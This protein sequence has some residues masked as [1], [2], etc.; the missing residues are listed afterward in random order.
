MP[1]LSF[2]GWGWSKKAINQPELQ[3]RKVGKRV[4]GDLP[5]ALETL[6]DLVTVENDLIQP[7][8]AKIKES[9]KNAAEGINQILDTKHTFT[10]ESLC[11]QLK[12]I[13]NFLGRNWTT[14]EGR[15][16]EEKQNI[17]VYLKAMEDITS[18]L[19]VIDAF[20]PAQ[21]NKGLFK[22]FEKHWDRQNI[23]ATWSGKISIKSNN[24]TTKHNLTGLSAWGKY[25]SDYSAFH[26]RNKEITGNSERE[27]SVNPMKWKAWNPFK[28]KKMTDTKLRAFSES[29]ITYIAAND[30]KKQATA[31]LEHAQIANHQEVYT[32]AQETSKKGIKACLEMKTVDTPL[33]SRLLIE[34]A[35]AKN[36]GDMNVILD[37][38]K[39][40]D[41]DIATLLSNTDLTPT[42]LEGLLPK[43]NVPDFK[44]EINKCLDKRFFVMDKVK[45]IREHNPKITPNFQPFAVT[46][47]ITPTYT[48]PKSIT[49]INV[50][51]VTIDNVRAPRNSFA[52]YLNILT[53]QTG[54]TGGT[55]A[56]GTKEMVDSDET[57]PRPPRK[58]I[59]QELQDS[60]NDKHPKLVIKYA[61]NSRLATISDEKNEPVTLN[62]KELTALSRA[63]PF[64]LISING[65]SYFVDPNKDKLIPYTT[66]NLINCFP[67]NI[68]GNIKV[69]GNDIKITDTRDSDKVFI[70]SETDDHDD[71]R[72]IL[73]LFLQ[74]IERNGKFEWEYYPGSTDFTITNAEITVHNPTPPA[75]TPRKGPAGGTKK[76][77]APPRPPRKVIT[78][79]LQTSV[80]KKYPKLG[81]TLN[82]N[83]S[84]TI[85]VEGAA[86]NVT[87]NF[88]ELTALSR[89]KPFEPISINGKSY[90]VDPNKDKLI[91]YN[92]S[93]S[94]TDDDSSSSSVIY[95]GESESSSVSES[96]YSS[97]FE[98]F[99]SDSDS[100]NSESSTAEEVDTDTNLEG[101][102]LSSSSDSEVHD[103]AELKER[104][105]SKPR[106]TGEEKL[107]NFFENDNVK[108]L[109]HEIKNSIQGCEIENITGSEGEDGIL[110]LFFTDILLTKNYTIQV[111]K[112]ESQFVIS[113][114]KLEKRSENLNIKL[115]SDLIAE[116]NE[117]GSSESWPNEQ[118]EK[119]AAETRGVLVAQQEKLVE[120]IGMV[121]E[122]SLILDN[123]LHGARTKE[124]Y[125]DK[126]TDW[127]SA[128]SQTELVDENAL[129][130]II[131]SIDAINYKDDE[132]I[133]L[134]G[135]NA[136]VEHFFE[137]NV[138]E[139]MKS[140]T[141]SILMMCLFTLLPKL[142]LEL[143]SKYKNKFDPDTF[144]REFEGYLVD[145]FSNNECTFQE[146]NDLYSIGISNDGT[147]INRLIDDLN[148]SDESIGEALFGQLDPQYTERFINY[149]KPKNLL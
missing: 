147:D 107:N 12:D 116:I 60:V 138:T 20:Q 137:Y 21:P 134:A 51:P 124:E 14:I 144:N 100:D 28:G 72:D 119:T 126:I 128:V 69:N 40:N 23:T 65:K 115:F 96:E 102:S 87:L 17:Q 61:K 77:V 140:S 110:T 27:R 80:N 19:S 132:K 38:V 148:D 3:A 78:P 93:D 117:S 108:D 141:S 113:S 118:L 105:S 44:K 63:V 82:E 97:S 121:A 8:K 7:D 66:E 86:D 50:T 58:A 10:G 81:I 56:G 25:F 120:A 92:D 2:S 41:E 89:A 71:P 104:H 75:R 106:R 125:E 101:A 59:T 31:Y 149:Y 95:S 49:I 54:G 129:D 145:K 70:I 76:R 88:K 32:V 133:A 36:N 45:E 74:E 48:A 57:P 22:G 42:K 83:G 135:F 139:Q 53:T 73:S 142:R 84:A 33:L 143:V 35:L 47:N 111:K 85:P 37:L 68:K 112:E 91:P 43:I 94:D 4:Q 11:D 6:G 131:D 136:A 34:N 29:A 79:E 9:I 109:I 98:S 30:Y 123:Y 122:N 1:G 55:S 127:L 16:P 24:Q 5:K 13:G 46:P 146:F 52:G 130:Q 39:D 18:A 114:D 26:T 90:F 103:D 64:E 99:S 15:N 67:K 62:F